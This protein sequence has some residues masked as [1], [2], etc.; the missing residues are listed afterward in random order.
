MRITAMTAPNPFLLGILRKSPAILRDTVF[1]KAFRFAGNAE[2]L[3][4]V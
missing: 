3:R 4:G 2:P 1:A